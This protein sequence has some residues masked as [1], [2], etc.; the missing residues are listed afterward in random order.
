[1][2]SSSRKK[3]EKKKD[4]QVSRCFLSFVFIVLTQFEKPKL[5]VGKTKARPDNFTDTSFKSKCQY[6]VRHC[7]VVVD[8]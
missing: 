4:F 5:R 7:G 3:K 8:L 6:S 1:M 2:G